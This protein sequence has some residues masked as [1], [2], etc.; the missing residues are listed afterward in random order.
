MLRSLALSSLIVAG[1]GA[2]R[3][4]DPCDER[5][6]VLEARLSRAA[7]NA[8]PSG[9]PP[10]VP[11]PRVDT[12]ASIDGAPPL[13]VVSDEIVFTGRGVGGTDDIERSAET[14]RSDI[15]SW[16]RANRRQSG[17]ELRIALWVAPD[18][19]V[20]TLV[21]LLRH[22]PGHARFALL[23]RGPVFEPGAG[24]PGW[25]PRAFRVRTGD[26]SGQRLRLESA[27]ARAT[28]T[29]ERARGHLPLPAPLAPAGPPLGAPTVRG[30][31][32]ALRACRCT[33]TD[34]AA[35]E[36]VATRA[37]VDRDG[38]VFRLRPSLRFGP[39][40]DDAPALELRPGDDVADLVAQ[41]EGRDGPLWV[42]VDR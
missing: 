41:L 32:D 27:W 16:A 37:L 28:E 38:P 1:C 22:A 36:A 3:E 4:A 9:S 33:G 12:G 10:D 7:A 17:D 26:P 21:R 19:L 5:L 25:V 18:V 31:M 14:L 20:D 13:L 39:P 30:L 23:V 42:R 40:T 34:L 6:V 24:E 15:R 11:L 2:V 8:E 35:I 29:C